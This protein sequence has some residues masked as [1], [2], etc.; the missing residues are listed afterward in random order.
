M[1]QLSTKTAHLS[2][3]HKKEIAFA[4]SLPEAR[5]AREAAHFWRALAHYN[6]HLEDL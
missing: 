5:R 1:L 3:Q 2:R 6:T 4:A